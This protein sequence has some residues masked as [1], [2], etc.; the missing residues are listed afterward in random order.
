M[1]DMEVADYLAHVDGRLAQEEE[2][3]TQ[4]FEASTRR[5]LMTSVENALIAAHTDAILRKGFGRLVDEARVEVILRS[6][7]LDL[8]ICSR[9]DPPMG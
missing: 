5:P 9:I 4:Y 8:F 3:Q 6:F 7:H 1:A 2:R